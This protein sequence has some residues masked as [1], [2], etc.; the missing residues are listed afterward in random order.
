MSPQVFTGVVPFNHNPPAV[1]MLAIMNGK[2]PPQP[3][4]PALT[5]QLWTVMWRCWDQNSH[6]RLEILEVL[7]VLGGS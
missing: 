3:T 5:E 4:H 7:K 1:A 2:C 6:S